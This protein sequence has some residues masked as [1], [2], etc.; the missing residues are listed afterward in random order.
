VVDGYRNS[1]TIESLLFLT[2]KWCFVYVSFKTIRSLLNA[3]IS[4]NVC[5]VSFL[6]AVSAR[7]VSCGVGD[8]FKFFKSMDCFVT[9]E[10]LIELLIEGVPFDSKLTLAVVNC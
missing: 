1:W 3:I 7:S 2:N 10:F 9:T 4:L 5:G 8:L 6:Y